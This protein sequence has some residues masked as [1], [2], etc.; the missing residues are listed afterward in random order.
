M[1]HGGR[2]YEQAAGKERVQD[3]HRQEIEMGLEIRVKTRI[4]IRINTRIPRSDTE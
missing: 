3:Y 2:G 4:N 1:Q